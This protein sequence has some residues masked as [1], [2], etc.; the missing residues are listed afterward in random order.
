MPPTTI[1]TILPLRFD[2]LPVSLLFMCHLQ[3]HSDWKR[4]LIGI[5]IVIIIVIVI[6]IFIIVIAATLRDVH[7]EASVDNQGPTWR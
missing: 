2:V 4:V 3:Q 5:I 7:A 6:I 1:F